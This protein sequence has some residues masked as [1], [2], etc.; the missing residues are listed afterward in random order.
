M[1][2]FL[3]YPDQDFDRQRPLPPHADTL[4]QDLELDILLQAM[5]GDD[6]FMLEVARQ[7][8]LTGLD[9]LATIRYRQE[10]LQ[11]CLRNT[12]VVR[13]LY[14][15]PIEAARNKRKGWMGIYSSYPSGILSGAVELVKMFMSLLETLKQLADEHASNFRSAGFTRFFA[16]IQAELDD[17][18]FA[19][20]QD[21]LKE[22]K[23][24]DGVM[25]SA[26]LGKGNEG[27]KYVLRKANENDQNWLERLLTAGPTTYSFRLHPRDDHGA[28][29]V[30]ELKN[31]G[32]NLVANALA[33]S[34]D[35]IDSFFTMLRAELAFY[36]G[37][38]NLAEQLQAIDMPFVTPKPVAMHTRNHTFRGLYDVC[39]A[40]TTQQKVVGNEATAVDKELVII[41]GANQGG[42][43]T[44]LRSIGLA[45]LMMQCGMFV[46]ANDF[47]A[48]LCHGVFT[49]FK[50]EEDTTMESG[51]LDEELGRM[52]EI[53]NW[54]TTD[55]LVLFNESFAATNER[56][57]SEI[58]RQIVTALLQ[59]RVKIYFVT[60]QYEFARRF[61]AQELTNTLFLRAQR[62]TDGRRTF[63]LTPGKPL[64]TSFG[65]DLYHRVFSPNG[66]EP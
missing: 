41:T 28:R 24:N 55:S 8:I 27:D 39:L 4:I 46:P 57:G 44:F 49:H 16:M 1:K 64:P 6:E 60:H 25:I 2:A 34:S 62:L 15:I 63:K 12:A 33:Q 66:Q 21:H 17:A 43:S 26:T 32:V 18:Y 31:R 19:T 14:Q 22:L 54:V 29:A 48:N 58:A 53:I 52:S 35:H 51:K 7:A 13:E 10:I 36:V 38:L 23:F 37:C 61:Y 9:D 5:A 11:D 59:K 45:Q 40:L 42:K 50:R 56:E 20:V 65:V 3:M 47:S 30:S